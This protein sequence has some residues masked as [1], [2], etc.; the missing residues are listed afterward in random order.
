MALDEYDSEDDRLV[1]ILS[2]DGEDQV[3]DLM[4]TH[5]GES[6]ITFGDVKIEEDGSMIPLDNQMVHSEDYCI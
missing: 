3:T 2:R 1:S 4:R 5:Y 6:P